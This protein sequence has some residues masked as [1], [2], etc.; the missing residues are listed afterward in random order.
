M[1]N[2]YWSLGTASPALMRQAGIRGAAAEDI[3]VEYTQPDE[4]VTEEFLDEFTAAC[5]GSGVIP[6]IGSVSEEDFDEERLRRIRAVCGTPGMGARHI[7]QTFHMAETV[8]RREMIQERFGTTPVAW[9]YDHGFLGE[10]VLGS[11]VVQVTGEEIRMLRETGT[12]VVNTPLC[13]MK[14][15]DGIAPISAMVREGVNV[16]LGSDGAMWNNS[17]DIFREMKGMVLLQNAAYGIRALTAKDALRMATVNGARAVG[18]GDDFG[19]VEEGKMAD[20]ILIRTDVPH[21]RPL[22]TGDGETVTSA[23]VFNAVGS[24][25][26]DVFVGGER[27][28]EEGVLQ[29]ADVEELCGRVQRTAEKLRAHEASRP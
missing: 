7:R 12:S 4:F 21:M 13:E 25:V 10:D 17:N 18:A 15:A 8:W 11:H 16:C 9:L 14:I 26:T 29:T 23:V 3:R 24:D 2:M 27:V 6:Y 19:T 22:C 1:E 5:G 20:L 28:V